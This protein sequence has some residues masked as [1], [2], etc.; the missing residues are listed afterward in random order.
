MLVA[1]YVE[2]KNNNGAFSLSANNT[3]KDSIATLLMMP[4]ATNG[5]DVCSFS[6]EPSDSTI[7]SF[8]ERS[9][10][11]G[12]I[13]YTENSESCGPIACSFGDT[14]SVSCDAGSSC[15]CDYSC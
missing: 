1:A 6:G 15:S 11:C 14:A 12:P 5:M 9:E 8:V 3:A 10:S 7:L 13:A 2:Q 4:T